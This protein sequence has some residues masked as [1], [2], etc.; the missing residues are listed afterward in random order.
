MLGSNLI[1]SQL[2]GKIR[3][4]YHCSLLSFFLSLSTPN[5]MYICI[6]C[7]SID[8][9][10]SIIIQNDEFAQKQGRRNWN[11]EERERK[12]LQCSLVS[13]FS[14]LLS[15]PLLSV[16]SLVFSEKALFFLVLFVFLLLGNTFSNTCFLKYFL[17]F[18][19]N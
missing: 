6:D 3:T 4:G 14:S 10:S 5:Y 17:R 18:L 16:F 12:R 8:I 13:L 15:S 11:Y 19:K 1:F 7:I 9:Y 2:L